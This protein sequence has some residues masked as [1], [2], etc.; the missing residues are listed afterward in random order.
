MCENSLGTR[1][2]EDAPGALDLGNPDTVQL[3]AGE[4]EAQLGENA[5]TKLSGGILLRREDRL[6]GA[7]TATYDPRTRSVFLGGNVRF[8]DPGHRG[9]Q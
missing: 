7:D 2:Y 6:A 4:F 3:E 1:L 9:R 8:Q 5:T